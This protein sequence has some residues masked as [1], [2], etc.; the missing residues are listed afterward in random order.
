MLAGALIIFTAQYRQVTENTIISVALIPFGFNILKHPVF[1]RIFMC[2]ISVLHLVFPVF[3]LVYVTF[4]WFLAWTN[5]RSVGIPP[6]LSIKVMCCGEYEGKFWERSFSD[7]L[8][9]VI[10]R[11]SEDERY[12][13]KWSRK[14]ENFRHHKVSMDIGKTRVIIHYVLVAATNYYSL[15]S[16]LTKAEPSSSVTLSLA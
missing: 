10:I 3:F 5:V 14:Q 7:C 9:T 1:F 8:M 16:Q 12:S 13:K 2:G 15:R 11:F 4:I 6:L